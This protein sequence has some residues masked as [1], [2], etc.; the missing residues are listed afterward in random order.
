MSLLYTRSG[1]LSTQKSTDYGIKKV[2]L[3]MDEHTILFYTFLIFVVVFTITYSTFCIYKQTKPHPSTKMVYVL[4][5]HG[6]RGF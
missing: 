2:Y 5:Q 1:I 3:F 6:R 4:M